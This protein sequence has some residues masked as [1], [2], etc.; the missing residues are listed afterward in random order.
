[1][2]ERLQVSSLYRRDL[3]HDESIVNIFLFL[4]AFFICGALLFPVTLTFISYLKVLSH[5]IDPFLVLFA[6]DFAR[7]KNFV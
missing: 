4:F 2:A 3:F 7:N 1:M 6:N 5:D